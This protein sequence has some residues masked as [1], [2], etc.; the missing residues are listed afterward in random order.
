MGNIHSRL[1]QMVVLGAAVIT[2]SGCATPCCDATTQTSP[3]VASPR[4]ITAIGHGSSGNY[5]QYGAGQQRLMATR[6]AQVDAYRNL[7]ERVH[8]FQVSGATA[9]SAFA[10]QSDTVRSYVDA[11]I[12][13]ARLVGVTAGPDGTYEATVE[14]DLTSQFVACVKAPSSC[15]TPSPIAS[16]G[17]NSMMYI[18]GGD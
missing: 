16:S 3:A 17:T 18:G 15:S 9:V 14:L 4:K 1:H 10:T 5:G 13:G 12:R 11:Y 2:L 6:A 8:G 7:V